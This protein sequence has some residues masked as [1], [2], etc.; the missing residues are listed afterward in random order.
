MLI[1]R[2]ASRCLIVLA[3]ALNVAPAAQAQNFN[4][5]TV[6]EGIDDWLG[7]MFDFRAEDMTFGLGVATGFAPDY[8]GSDRYKNV[9]LPVFQLRYKDKFTLDPL[10]ARLRV[11][12]SDCCRLRAV[13]SLSESRQA[14]QGTPTSRLPDVD[15]GI[16]TGFIFEGRIYGPF[17]FR[18]NARKEIAGGHGGVTISPAVGVILRNKADTYS[19]IPEIALTW[20]NGKYMDAFFSITPLGAASGL[21]LY[22]A[23]SGPR[24]VSARLTATYRFNQ[25]WMLIGRAQAS[26]LVSDAKRSPLVA[27]KFQGLLG[28]GVMYTF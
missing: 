21:P 13:L 16:N 3:V 25:D 28:M 27:D 24:E 22:D 2:L 18:L 23:D 4:D 14:D 10:G 9:T 7:D 12:K 5:A 26:R 1:R 8:P 20:G 11:W 19:V 6:F 17:A 15:R